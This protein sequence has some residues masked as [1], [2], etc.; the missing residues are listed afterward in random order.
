MTL[1]N[2]I[3]NKGVNKVSKRKKLIIYTICPPIDKINSKD[4]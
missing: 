2:I 3:S 4:Y 1:K